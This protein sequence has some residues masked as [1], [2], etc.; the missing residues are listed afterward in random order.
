MT[1]RIRCFLKTHWIAPGLRRI[2]QSTMVMICLCLV[3][4]RAA[5]V[6]SISFTKVP[7]ASEGGSRVFETITGRVRGSLPNEKIVIF[8]KSNFWWIQ[9]DRLKPYTDIQT[10]GS[11]SSS[12]HLGTEYA[13]LLVDDRYVP[14]PVMSV[15]PG[16]G[17]G[18][19]AVG[20]VAGDTST[21]APSAAVPQIVQF[22][23]YD[24]KV[25]SIKSNRGGASHA[26]EPGNVLIDS[27]GL[28]HLKITQAKDQWTC[29]D[30][31]LTRSLAY[32]TYNFQVRDISHLE[33]AATLSL[34]TWGDDRSSD[35]DHHELDINISRR[36]DPKND[37]A[38][39]V[40]QPYYIASNVFRFNVP[41]GSM[42]YSFDW[43]PESVSFQTWRG[44]SH[45]AA[46]KPISGHTFVSS[47]PTSG[48][49]VAHISLCPFG[50]S[51]VPLR[52][53]AEVVI[54]RFQ[55]LP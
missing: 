10:D 19:F 26:Y 54:E 2:E 14:L 29:A 40:V 38:E 34:Y 7:P 24:W 46:T 35:M 23:G 22:S 47:V 25:R 8:A 48:G 33:P 9:P 49:E 16:K 11:W 52:H 36:G 13:A 30:V 12:I 20:R 27:S 45:S 1:F 18:V 21:V 6:P 31:E 39:Y 32:G 15:L 37:N 53:D 4:C 51:K 3:G 50:F 28:M 42:T 44:V 5:A 41:S 17:N 43:E 55:Y